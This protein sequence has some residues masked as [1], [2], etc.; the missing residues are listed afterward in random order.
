MT[1]NQANLYFFF[2][3]SEIEEREIEKREREEKLEFSSVWQAEK[4]RGENNN[5]WALQLFVFYLD[6]RRKCKDRAKHY[7]NDSYAIEHN[8]FHI[9]LFIIV[10]NYF[11][12][13]DQHE[14]L[15]VHLWLYMLW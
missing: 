9:V 4:V 14:L 1:I 11:L 2:G 13:Q 12:R 7:Q 3:L 15:V 10:F 6:M 8:V 5:W